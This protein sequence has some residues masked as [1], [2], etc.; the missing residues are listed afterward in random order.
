MPI[1]QSEALRPATQRTMSRI[2]DKKWGMEGLY[3]WY[4]L[5]THLTLQWIPRP[6]FFSVSLYPTHSR[7]GELSV[8]TLRFPQSFGF[9]SVEMNILNISFPGMEIET[10]NLSRL[11]SHVSLPLRRGRPLFYNLI[12]INICKKKTT[13]WT[14]FLFQIKLID[15]IFFRI[16]LQVTIRS[17]YYINRN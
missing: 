4:P 10:P 11:Q 13:I 14:Y 17:V 16:T 5:P 6:T 8:K 15:K 2:W 7:V 3:N 9:Q 12:H 1:I